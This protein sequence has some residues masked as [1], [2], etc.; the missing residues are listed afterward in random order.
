M[1]AA[2]WIDRLALANLIL[3]FIGFLAG[4]VLR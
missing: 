1:V 4:A 2:R 3:A